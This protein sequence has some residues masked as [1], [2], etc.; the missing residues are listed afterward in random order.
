M[1]N[2]FRNNENE[3]WTAI[4]SDGF[5]RMFDKRFTEDQAWSKASH[6]DKGLDSY[7]DGLYQSA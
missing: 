2:V 5:V 7:M 1:I 6:Y 4:L 3:D